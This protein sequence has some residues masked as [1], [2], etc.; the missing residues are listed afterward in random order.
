MVGRSILKDL[1]LL[2]N[3]Q[4]IHL[5]ILSIMN[6]TIIIWLIDSVRVPNDKA[7]I[8]LIFGYPLL[9]VLNALILVILNIFKRP[10]QRI[11]KMTT[12]SLV[13]LFFPILFLSTL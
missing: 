8:L 6:L 7:M 11:Y 9:T 12:I 4:K 10:E 5:I 1:N 13:V 3:S 2:T